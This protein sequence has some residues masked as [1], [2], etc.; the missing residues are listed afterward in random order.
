MGFC[1]NCGRKLLDDAKF[2]PQCGTAIKGQMIGSG[3]PSPQT[4]SPT[5]AIRHSEVISWE[6]S[7]KLLFNPIIWKDFVKVWGIS[8]GLLT[9][10][11]LIDMIK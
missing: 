10:L 5:K 2:C 3:A 6:I 8:I 9:Y 1:I 11:V 7:I 4:A